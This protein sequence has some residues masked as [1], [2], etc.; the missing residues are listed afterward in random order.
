MPSTLCSVLCRW[1]LPPA[2]TAWLR[3]ALW[4][5][6]GLLLAAC[7]WLAIVL[8]L[9]AVATY[10]GIAPSRLAKHPIFRPW[11]RVI[12]CADEGIA[13]HTLEPY[14]CWCDIMSARE[15]VR[16]MADSL[17]PRPICL[18]ESNGSD[19][20]D[21]NDNDRKW[22]EVAIKMRITLRTLRQQT[23]SLK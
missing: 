7:S 16:F 21:S 5:R 10:S 6:A 12:A 20:V 8:S 23:A 2:S 18:G 19:V 11:L 17:D 4:F 22:D 9:P 13:R 14:W 3:A 15:R 1:P